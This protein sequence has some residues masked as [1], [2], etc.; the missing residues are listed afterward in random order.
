MK[1]GSKFRRVG[2]VVALSAALWGVGANPAWSQEPGGQAVPWEPMFPSP[3]P[4]RFT[5]SLGAF[6]PSE[7]TRR[8]TN[9]VWAV[10]RFAYDLLPPS[11][12]RAFDVAAYFDTGFGTR[13]EQQDFQEFLQMDRQFH[14]L[15]LSGTLHLTP[16]TSGTA[17]F[18]SAGGGPYLLRRS[19]ARVFEYED[20]D[21]EIEEIRRV[22][23]NAQAVTLGYRLGAGLRFG[24]G[25]FFEAAYQDMG[26]LERVPYRG[27]SASVGMHF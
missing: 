21:G 14:G 23:G 4:P 3:R 8:G 12:S 9:G 25:F 2:F 6:F 26:R 17:F 5:A 22:L 27:A 11:Q 1:Q 16:R 7:D 20:V 19:R 24:R 15:G 18:V 10:G 13:R